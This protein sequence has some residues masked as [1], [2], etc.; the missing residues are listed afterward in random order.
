MASWTARPSAVRGAS[1]VTRPSRA[2]CRASRRWAG[3]R[4]RPT[5]SARG[6][7]TRMGRRRAARAPERPAGARRGGRGPEPRRSRSAGPK[8][9]GIGTNGIRWRRASS[10][11]ALWV[12]SPP[13]QQIASNSGPQAPAH[14]VSEGRSSNAWIVTAEPWRRRSRPSRRATPRARPS[15]EPGVT[16][17][18]TDRH[19]EGMSQEGAIHL[20]H[21]L[22]TQSVFWAEVGRTAGPADGPPE[23]TTRQE[24]P[25][26]A[27]PRFSGGGER[28]PVHLGPVMGPPDRGPPRV[29]PHRGAD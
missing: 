20:P 21:A 7:V 27:G 9:V 13:T 28:V 1:A 14:S 25:G 8:P 18:Q 2:P 3:R 16:T 12:A 19:R 6:V 23:R 22:A 11:A 15:P 5:T 24:H 10:A 29:P 26:A 4:R 17:I